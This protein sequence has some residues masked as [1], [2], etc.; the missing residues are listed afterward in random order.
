MDDTDFRIDTTRD[1]DHTNDFAAEEST[2]LNS[3]KSHR[4]GGITATG[5]RP[6]LVCHVCRVHGLVR[7]LLLH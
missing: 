2:E 6:L 1:F 4:R 5:L 3:T 7:S